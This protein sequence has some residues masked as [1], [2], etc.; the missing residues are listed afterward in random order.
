MREEWKKPKLATKNDVISYVHF[1]IFPFRSSNFKA[2]IQVCT[3]TYVHMDV[4][5]GSMLLICKLYVYLPI[6][7]DVSIL[8]WCGDVVMACNCLGILTRCVDRKNT[9]YYWCLL[10]IETYIR[11]TFISLIYCYNFLSHFI[12]FGFAWFC[13]ASIQLCFSF[14]FILSS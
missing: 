2:L 7:K 12:S 8:C 10:Y 3:Y 6:A 9:H 11:C 14:F 13:F 5:I 1:E 4:W